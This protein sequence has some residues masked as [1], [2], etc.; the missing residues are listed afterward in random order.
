MEVTGIVKRIGEVQTFGNDFTKR[1]IVITT[2]DQYPQHLSIEFFKDKTALLNNYSE[3]QK[4]KISINLNGREWV[5]PEG[6]VKYFNTISGWRIESLSTPNATLSEAFEPSNVNA[7]T[8]D[9]DDLP[10]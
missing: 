8:E 6:D 10:F 5:S 7:N 1:E 3:G 2:E 9:K 4:V